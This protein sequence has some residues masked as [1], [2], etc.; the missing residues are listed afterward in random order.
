MVP[1]GAQTIGMLPQSVIQKIAREADS[2]IFDTRELSNPFQFF[3]FGNLALPLSTKIVEGKMI[4]VKRIDKKGRR[5][6]DPGT[7]LKGPLGGIFKVL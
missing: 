3:P 6:S 7:S 4:M 5:A 2:L 1:C